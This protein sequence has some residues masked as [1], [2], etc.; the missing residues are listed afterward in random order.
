[1]PAFISFQKSFLIFILPASCLLSGL[2]FPA[3][4]QESADMIIWKSL[5]TKHTILHFQSQDDLKKFHNKIN[6]GP[7]Q[8]GFSRLFTSS[9]PA[10]AEKVTQQVDLLFERV[11]EILDMRKKMDSVLIN[12]YA[13][14][15][16]LVD[17]FISI[18]HKPCN[19][20]A[21][22]RYKDNTIYLSINDLHEGMLAHELAHSI[23][24]HYLL[25][26]PPMASAEILARYVDS[27]LKD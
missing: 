16:Q 8:W 9:P 22:Y 4:G 18:Y 13:N 27:H 7:S 11:Q 19:I 17:T 21:W 15:E 20:R 2:F 12:I 3:F 6:F 10:L 5:A 1:M 24:D 26:R 25:I 14:R 23:I